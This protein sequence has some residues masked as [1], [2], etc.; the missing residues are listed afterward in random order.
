MGS[1]RSQGRGVRGAPTFGRMFGVAL[2]VG[3]SFVRVRRA[4]ERRAAWACGPAGRRNRKDVCFSVRSWDR[5][6]GG[7]FLVCPEGALGLGLVRTIRRPAVLGATVRGWSSAPRRRGCWSSAPRVP[8]ARL[9]LGLEAVVRFCVE[10]GWSGF[11]GNR[12]CKTLIYTPVLWY[13]GSII[14]NMEYHEM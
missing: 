10:V 9:G 1:G 5:V 14:W 11:R 2:A 12:Y 8:T 7:E 3:R 6:P 13:T 4:A